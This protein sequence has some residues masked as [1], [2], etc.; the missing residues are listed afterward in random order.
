MSGKTVVLPPMVVYAYPPP[1]SSFDYGYFGGGFGYQY[2]GSFG[3]GVDM[4][5]IANHVRY[6]AG[7]N[8]QYFDLEGYENH[9]NYVDPESDKYLYDALVNF[10]LPQ[11]GSI[12]EF[13]AEALSRNL[14]REE[15]K[16]LKAQALK[17][18]WAI[19]VGMAGATASQDIDNGVA[20]QVAIGT[21]VAMLVGSAG[22]ITGTSLG[23]VA[24]AGALA[25]IALPGL[26][27]SLPVGF[28]LSLIIEKYELKEGVSSLLESLLE[29]LGIEKNANPDEPQVLTD[30][31]LYRVT[32]ALVDDP[33]A[34]PEA[35][36]MLGE[37]LQAVQDSLPVPESTQSDE[38]PLDRGS[39]RRTA[40][41]GIAT[42]T[43]KSSRSSGAGGPRR[44]SRCH[45]RA[46]GQGTSSRTS[47]WS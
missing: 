1:P 19:Q 13:F 39:P 6:L 31:D 16:M 46:Y 11:L 28:A 34:Y 33:Q 47:T 18:N 9:H 43:R 2:G 4:D 14:S 17:G 27:V 22:V 38:T 32:K 5:A 15:F 35:E 25:G 26:A 30:Y 3:F 7:L 41:N 23:I 45:P 10:A 44:S 37:L 40:G 12:P 24:G 20:P 29:L 36:A 8:Q 42:S 21:Q